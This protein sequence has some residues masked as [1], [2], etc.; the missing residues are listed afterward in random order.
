MPW[1]K[2]DDEFR[3]PWIDIFQNRSFDKVDQYLSPKVSNKLT[4]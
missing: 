3:D 2:R 1:E 4:P